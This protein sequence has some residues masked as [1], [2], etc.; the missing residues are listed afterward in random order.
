MTV[1][2][3]F[4]IVLMIGIIGFLTMIVIFSKLGA[5]AADDDPF[6]DPMLNPNIRVHESGNEDNFVDSMGN[7]EMKIPENVKEG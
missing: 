2:K 3:K 6:L 5:H 7:V 4:L 1:R